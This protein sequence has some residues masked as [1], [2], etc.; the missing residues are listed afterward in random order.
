MSIR[1]I[2][3]A[4]EKLE[5]KGADVCIHASMKAFGESF[6]DADSLIDAFLQN[7]CTIMVPTFSHD[8]EVCPIPS[9]MPPQ[10]GAGD[11]S[12][13]LESE[14]KN[15][16]PFTTDSKVISR[17]SM[18]IFPERVLMRESSVRG[19][20]PLNSFTAV[21]KNAEKLISCQ[22]KKEVYAPFRQLIEN[23]GYVLLIGVGLTS[24]TII[25]YAEQLSGRNPFLRWCLDENGQVVAALTG[26]CS[27]GFGNFSEVLLPFERKITVGESVWTLFKASEIA[28][29][30][31]KAIE[32]NPLITH[33][34]NEDCH[35]CNDAVK[36]GP[37]ISRFLT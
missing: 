4:I 11:Y 20:H 28:E 37:D 18:G 10:N 17:S 16:P 35:R 1:E 23:D 29:V 27:R 21:G 5:L 8:Y 36:G 30:C 9:L 31:R 24:A 32:E 33:C 2:N 34:Q 7:D 12:F 3:S 13:F 15:L 26:S 22:T 25:H 19:N 14:Y 6:V